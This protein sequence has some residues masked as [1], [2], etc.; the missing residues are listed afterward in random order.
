MQ[1]EL[2][3][4]DVKTDQKVILVKP[5]KK[6]TFAIS[7]VVIFGDSSLEQSEEEET[8]QSELSDVEVQT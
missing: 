8:D 1:N 5:K 3:S 4:K 2:G 7:D 6:V